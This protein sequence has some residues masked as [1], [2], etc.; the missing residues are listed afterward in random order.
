MGSTLTGVALYRLRGYREDGRIE[1]PLPNGET[2][3]VV[4]MSRT[5]STK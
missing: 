5:L 3:P 1:V 4:H 2:L